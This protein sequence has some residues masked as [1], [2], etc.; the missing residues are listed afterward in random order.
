MKTLFT[1]IFLCFLS[2]VSFGQQIRIGVYRD[3][4]I[5]RIVF[6]HDGTNYSVFADTSYVGELI[7]EGYIEIQ[8]T[9]DKRLELFIGIISQGIFD[10]I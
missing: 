7:N 6:A 4:D 10:K 1:F 5:Q 9:T 8:Q 3:N 2:L